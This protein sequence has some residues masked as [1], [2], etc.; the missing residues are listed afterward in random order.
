MERVRAGDIVL[1]WPRR[2]GSQ[3]EQ[4]GVKNAN[5][6]WVDGWDEGRRWGFKG[7]NERKG[8]G[9]RREGAKE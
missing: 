3:E 4:A 6:F 9:A 8:G 2:T 5:M 7:E 1:A